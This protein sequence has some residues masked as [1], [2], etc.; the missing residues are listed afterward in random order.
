M[1]PRIGRKEDQG[2]ELDKY[3]TENRVDIIVENKM[4]NDVV[5]EWQKLNSRMRGTSF[6]YC[7]YLCT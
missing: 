3:R 2:K 4:E 6:L 7:M 5:K 1:I